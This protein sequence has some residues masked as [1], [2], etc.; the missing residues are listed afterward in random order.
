MSRH[1]FFINGD[2]VVRIANPC[3]AGFQYQAVTHVV[4]PRS[5]IAPLQHSHAET[6][7]V[8]QTGTLEVMINGLEV[9]VGAGNFV[10]IPAKTWF[11]YANSTDAAAE[12]LVRTAPA[13]AVR[14]GLRVR[15]ELTAA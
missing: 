9:F 13:P 14:D 10:R 11:A 15:V 8:V 12:I 4:A 7:I 5:Q 2:R 6:V 3:G 1:A